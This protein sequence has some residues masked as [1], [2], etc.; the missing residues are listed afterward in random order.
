MKPPFWDSIEPYLEADKMRQ[1]IFSRLVVSV[2]PEG[3]MFRVY[4]PF[5]YYWKD[6]IEGEIIK[7]TVPVDFLTDFAS[8][9]PIVRLI[10]PKLGRYNAPA[11]I[12]DFLYRYHQ[13]GKGQ[14]VYAVNRKM[15][16]LIFLDA[17]RDRGVA[18]WKRQAMYYAVRIAGTFAWRK[19]V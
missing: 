18:V 17:M 19:R 14:I 7:I 5:I 15:A 6:R 16:D 11:V 12:H 4:K 3:N 2:M 10:I 8:I 13:I 9:P 1:K